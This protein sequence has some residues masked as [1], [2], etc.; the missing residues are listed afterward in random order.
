MAT[1]ALQALT[2][3]VK[4]G[5]VSIM[6]DKCLH[7]SNKLTKVQETVTGTPS[8]LVLPPEI[9]EDIVDNYSPHTLAILC[10]VSRAYNKIYTK[11]LYK[12]IDLSHSDGCQCLK[13]E[14]NR[15]YEKQTRFLQ[16]L[17][18]KKQ[19][20]SYVKT[21]KWT[22]LFDNEYG[23][24]DLPL[25]STYS[26][27]QPRG[28]WTIFIALTE[29]TSVEFAEWDFCGELSYYLP[30]NIFLFPKV[31]SISFQGDLTDT[32]V[33]YLLP[34]TDA[35]QLQHLRLEN[36]QINVDMELTI[37]FLNKFAARCTKLKSLMVFE[38]EM[39]LTSPEGDLGTGLSAYVRIIES[40]RETLETLYFEIRDFELGNFP[41]KE[42]DLK[43]I[44]STIQAVLGHG[45]WPRLRKATVVPFDTRASK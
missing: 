43:E 36:F 4:V 33:G 2:L 38:H 44:T 25:L 23:G 35:S 13:R 29:V 14:D 9:R 8:S 41:S 37:L 28:L 42:S 5:R 21:L 22:L 18:E 39:E 34:D 16:T 6:H 7:Q 17:K 1:K 31:A 24:V 26:A 11:K 27:T 32:F 30:K 20:A 3:V 10:R 12:N 15:C 40:A 19:Y 45:I